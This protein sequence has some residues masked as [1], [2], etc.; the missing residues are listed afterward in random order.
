MSQLYSLKGRVAIKGEKFSHSHRKYDRNFQIL[1]KNHE[2]CLNF[3][4]T[5]TPWLMLFSVLV[6]RHVNPI[7]H[8]K[9]VKWNHLLKHEAK[10]MLEKEFLVS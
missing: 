4:N 7:S 10:C 1:S 6:K 9:Q 2:A 5:P 3:L 8:I